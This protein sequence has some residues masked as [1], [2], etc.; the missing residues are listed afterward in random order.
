MD[1]ILYLPNTVKNL[2]VTLP[3][4]TKALANRDSMCVKREVNLTATREHMVKFILTNRSSTYS[5][6][7]LRIITGHKKGHI[8]NES[9]PAAENRTQGHACL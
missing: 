1:G 4:T 8:S 7:S 3:H 6:H 5:L 2:M 9:G